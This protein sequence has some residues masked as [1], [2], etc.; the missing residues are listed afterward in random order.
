LHAEAFADVPGDVTVLF[1][2][3]SACIHDM[4]KKYNSSLTI[5]QAPGLLEENAIA[6]QPLA[7]KVAVSLRTGLFQFKFAVDSS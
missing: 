6:S 4:F 3:L 1:R 2:D 7:G 5:N